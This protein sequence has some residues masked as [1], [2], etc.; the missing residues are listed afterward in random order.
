MTTAA[1]GG[2]GGASCCSAPQVPR[3]PA[4]R[5]PATPARQFPLS[6]DP[7]DASSFSLS[8]AA[9]ALLSLRTFHLP[10]LSLPRLPAA[11]AT[12]SAP[13]QGGYQGRSVPAALAHQTPAHVPAPLHSKTTLSAVTSTHVPL[14][15]SAEPTSVGPSL[16]RSTGTALAQV[17]DDHLRCPPSVLTLLIPQHH[18]IS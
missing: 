5:S 15:L 17:T 10:G 16:Q 13:S 2:G 4:P 3:P 1:G 7:Q 9:Q 6:S 11:P 18:W 12:S 14:L 8:A